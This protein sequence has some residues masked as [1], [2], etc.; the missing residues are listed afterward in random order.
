[1]SEVVA[2]RC[3]AYSALGKHITYGETEGEACDSM[4]DAGFY[5]Y[6]I[7]ALQVKTKETPN[8]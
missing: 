3:V 2:Y 6:E 7:E 8:D 5:S 1:M 4:E